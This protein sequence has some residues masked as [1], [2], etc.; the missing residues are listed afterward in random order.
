SLFASKPEVRKW[1]QS[2]R[3]LASIAVLAGGAFGSAYLPGIALSVQL[4][5]AVFFAATVW[6]FRSEPLIHV[7]VAGLLI[8]GL[9][10]ANR[11]VARGMTDRVCEVSL[12]VA[13]ESVIFAVVGVLLVPLGRRQGIPRWYHQALLFMPLVAVTLS[14]VVAAGFLLGHVTIAATV[15]TIAALSAVLLLVSV[16]FR[17]VDLFGFFGISLTAACVAYYALG[18][19]EAGVGFVDRYATVCLA[20]AYALAITSIV[21]KFA[22][23]GSESRKGFG[24]ALYVSAVVSALAALLLIPLRPEPLYVAF[25]AMLIAGVVLLDHVHR[26][27]PFINYVAGVLVTAAAYLLLSPWGTTVPDQWAHSLM[28]LTAVFA[29]GLLV[30]SL[31]LRWFL[32]G[33]CGASDRTARRQTTPLT[34]VGMALTLGLAGWL[35]VQEVR[36]FWDLLLHHD[37]PLLATLGPGAGFLAWMGVL[38]AFLIS[39]WLFRNTLRTVLFYVVG[40]CTACYLGFFWWTEAPYRYLIYAVGGYGSAHLMVYLYE[41]KFLGFLRRVCSFY[42]DERRASTHVFTLAAISTLVGTGLAA[43]RLGTH[44]ALIMLGI[45]SAVFLAWAFVWQRSA[46][47]Y[48]AIL[49]LTL[50]V[51]SVWHNLSDISAAQEWNAYR[52]N[53]NSAILCVSAL[54]WLGVGTRLEG[55][56]GE[57]FQLAFP[58]RNSSV[59]IAVLATGFA[60]LLTFVPA[61]NASLR[62]AEPRW[63]QI[64]IGALALCGLIGYWFWAGRV[65]RRRF[66]LIAAAVSIFTLGAYFAWVVFG[67]YNT[68]A[69]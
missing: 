6:R 16:T 57:M 36:V 37:S 33:V 28:L 4:P 32:R 61:F 42:R 48:P 11:F 63:G 44:E 1:Q 14:A 66:Y 9:A 60:A 62:Q 18:H 43:F 7:S 31:A 10:V 41:E 49:V 45:Q 12:A 38:A 39:M 67:L 47:L 3:L 19:T 56:R 20:A 58:A 23:R 27:R 40:I 54:F 52:V 50:A 21:L 30:V 8:A 35:A 13:G 25:D 29:I 34:V 64:A 65:F 22:L 2:G 53:I 5:V 51:L 68:P 69:L 55:A 24:G 59:I 15:L 17:Q 26:P 46:M